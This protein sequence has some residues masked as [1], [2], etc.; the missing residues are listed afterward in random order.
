MRLWA[1]IISSLSECVDHCSECGSFC[2]AI[3]ISISGRPPSGS[4]LYREM[5]LP[6]QVNSS[7]A[8]KIWAM[9]SNGRVLAVGLSGEPYKVHI[10]DKNGEREWC[11]TL[12]MSN[13][14]MSGYAMALSEDG[15]TLA[16]SM[17]DY[18]RASTQAF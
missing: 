7:P 1:L 13:S 4:A 10:F 16:V 6:P 8:Y 11:N 12:V 5:V 3:G 14:Q 9:S 15:S 17:G 18:Q 2:F